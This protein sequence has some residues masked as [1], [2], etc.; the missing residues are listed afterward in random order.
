MLK[1]GDLMCREMA[2]VPRHCELQ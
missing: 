1:C 2:G